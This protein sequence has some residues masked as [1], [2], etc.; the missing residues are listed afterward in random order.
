MEKE[1]SFYSSGIELNGIIN[2]PAE[3]RNTEV[4]I[5]VFSHG[6]GSGKDELGS[7]NF[8][9]DCLSEVGIA[10]LRF[11]MR[12]SGYSKYLM[13][14]KLCSTE[15]KEDLKSA[16]YFVSTYPGIDNNRIGVIGESM[17]GAIVIMAA[18]ETAKIKCVIALAPIADG[19]NLIKQNW[20]SNKKEEEYNDFLKDLEEDRIRRTKY[21]TSNLVK[22]SY[23]LAYC[24]KDTEIVDSI[25][26]TFEDKLFSYYVRYESID[27]V[28]D[29]KPIKFIDQ[30]APRPIL[31]LAGEEDTI[32]PPETNAKI[33]FKKA[34]GIKKLVL[35]KEGNHRLLS[36]TIKERVLKKIVSWVKTYL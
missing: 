36:G 5:V 15:W 14:K 3:V 29:L 11:D 9:S 26:K 18:A 21:G 12:G 10:S 6:Y 28:L 8:I 24:K 4:P 16:V 30:I 2:L 22:L 23:A 25:N 32:V 7:Y 19:C 34:K 17:G 27:S 33:L 13:G 35:F 20:Q 1:V 31:I